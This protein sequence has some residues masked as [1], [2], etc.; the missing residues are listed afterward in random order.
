[1]LE[2]HT[3]A[4]AYTTLVVLVRLGVGGKIIPSI[5]LTL[6]K[7][8]VE[9]KAELGTFPLV[10][11]SNWEFPPNIYKSFLVMPPLIIIFKIHMIMVDTGQL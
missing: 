1:M 6:A 7:V 8:L 4:R 5:R 3:P 11:R 9:V 10:G 2:N